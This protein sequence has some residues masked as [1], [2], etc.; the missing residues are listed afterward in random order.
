MLQALPNVEYVEAPYEDYPGLY[1]R[2]DVLLSPSR[3]EGGPIP[4]IEAMMSNIVPVAT[5]TG[6]CPD[7]IRDGENGFLFDAGASAVHIAA[8]IERAYALPADVR[9]GVEGLSWRAFAA[10]LDALAAATP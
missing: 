6:F 4:V 5:R 10:R 1:A 3:L 2:M 7:V 8:L 9:A